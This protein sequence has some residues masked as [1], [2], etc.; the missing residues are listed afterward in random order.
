MYELD[1]LKQGP[2]KLGDAAGDWLQ[3]A[4][5]AIQTRIERYAASEIKFSLLAI[6][7]NRK[8]AAQ[9]AMA[10][11]EARVAR[12]TAVLEGGAAP[13]ETSD[14]DTPDALAAQ[15]MQAQSTIDDLR[16]EVIAEEHKFEAWHQENIRRKHN[17]IPL[18]VEMLKV[19]AEKEKLSDL[20]QKAEAKKR[21]LLAKKA[22][23]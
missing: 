10:V 9:E 22:A 16:A 8:Q 2:I 5:Q 19:L 18:V 17:Y 11:E 20:V 13:M 21:E 7:K 3:V 14:A 15:R 1:G 6:C 4:R 23:A 12:I